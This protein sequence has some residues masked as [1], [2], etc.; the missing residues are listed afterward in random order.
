M[1]DL[2]GGIHALLFVYG[3]LNQ[4]AVQRLGTGH[5]R[6]SLGPANRLDQKWGELP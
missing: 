5:R 4:W 2:V 1:T 6:A 3:F